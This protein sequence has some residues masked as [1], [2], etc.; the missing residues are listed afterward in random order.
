M[1]VEARL[2][3][4]SEAAALSGIGL[5]TVNNAIDKKIIAL[6]GGLEGAKRRSL[7]AAHVLRLKLWHGVG[8]TL[9]A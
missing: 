9:S 2:F 4:P 6:V 3:S 1:S 8:A 7:T 5:K